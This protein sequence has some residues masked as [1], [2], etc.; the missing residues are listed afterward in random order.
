MFGNNGLLDGK[1]HIQVPV[2]LACKFLYGMLVS[3]VRKDGEKSRTRTGFANSS[4]R[5]AM[6]VQRPHV[7]GILTQKTRLELQ[8]RFL[9]VVVVPSAGPCD[10]RGRVLELRLA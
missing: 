4:V 8:N 7:C 2:I 9:R 1:N 10:L 6:M 5:L 3:R